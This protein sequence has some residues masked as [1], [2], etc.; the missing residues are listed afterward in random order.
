MRTPLGS[1]VPPR[2]LSVN[3]ARVQAGCGVQ[4]F[5]LGGSVPEFAEAGAGYM[6]VMVVSWAVISV[7]VWMGVMGLASEASLSVAYIFDP[8]GMQPLQSTFAR[9]LQ[10]FEHLYT[11]NLVRLKTLHDGDAE[12]D[13]NIAQG[14]G[15]KLLVAVCFHVLL[16][17]NAPSF[18]E[19]FS[20]SIKA[21][22]S[23]LGGQGDPEA[24]RKRC[25]DPYDS[26]QVF[27]P[28]AMRRIHRGIRESDPAGRARCGGLK[29]SA[30]QSDSVRCCL[31]VEE[32]SWKFVRRARPVHHGGLRCVLWDSF[33]DH[34]S[35]GTH[36][37][38]VS[39]NRCRCPVTPEEGD[40]L[41]GAYWA[42]PQ[43]DRLSV[44]SG[45]R[46]SKHRGHRHAWHYW[47]PPQLVP[48]L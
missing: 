41:A 26:V 6:V 4:A 45:R 29:L 40:L 19:V 20:R 8:H 28:T 14:L 42:V 24:R 35:R 32:R 9:P 18:S 17:T 5:S 15:T 33:R 39:D 37:R 13:A 10:A 30:F 47:V 48:D 3:H 1:P 23:Y 7:G 16:E 11:M 44:P 31:Q 34:V 46:S 21:R 36:F 12:L 2:L 22:V 38:L 27:Y 25:I 43:H